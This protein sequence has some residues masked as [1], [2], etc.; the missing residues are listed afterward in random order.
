[1]PETD[2]EFKAMRDRQMREP[3]LLGPIIEAQAPVSIADGRAAVKL[4]R[5]RAAE[6]GVDRDRIGILGFSAGGGVATGSATQ[7]AAGERPDFAALIYGAGTPD[8]SRRCS[9]G[10]HPCGRGRSDRAGG[11]QQSVVFAVAGGRAFG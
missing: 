10:F 3:E 7:Y 4:L 6:W 9:A 8:D 11:T 5:A 2:E 1:M